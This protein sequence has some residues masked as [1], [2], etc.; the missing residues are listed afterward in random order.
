MQLLLLIH[1]N[2]AGELD[3]QMLE[4]PDEQ[5]PTEL[6]NDIFMALEAWTLAPGDTIRIVEK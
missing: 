4:Y 1:E 2:G 6:S 3:R 5:N